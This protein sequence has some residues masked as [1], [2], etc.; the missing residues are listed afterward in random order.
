MSN[1]NKA[2]LERKLQAINEELEIIKPETLL[3]NVDPSIEAQEIIDQIKTYHN[4]IQKEISTIV[5]YS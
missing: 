4:L 5:T 3:M 2:S 1:K